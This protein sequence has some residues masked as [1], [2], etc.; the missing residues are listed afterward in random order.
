MNSFFIYTIE[1]GICLAAFQIAF[2]ILLRKDTFFAISR[3]YLLLTFI[4]SAILPA[5]N[6][7]NAVSNPDVIPTA[8]FSTITI[9]ASKA[10]QAVSSGINFG[11]I[12][13]VIYFTG[14]L[15]FLSRFIMRLLQLLNLTRK[16]GIRKID[17]YK[18]VF[19]ESQ[20]SPFSFFNIIFLGSSFTYNSETKNILAHEK[21]HIDKH[22]T[23]DILVAEIM[24]ILQWF[25]PFIWLIKMSLQEVHE[26]QA[27]EGVVKLGVDKSD[28]QKLILSKIAGSE[29]FQT[30]NNFSYQLIKRRIKMITK[31]KTKKIALV[32][33]MLIVPISLLLFLSFSCSQKEN[34]SPYEDVISIP[35]DKID[36]HAVYPTGWN[37]MWNFISSR[38][39][40][41][42]E[43]IEKNTCGK[44]AIRFE[45][46]IDGTIENV[47]VA[48][49]KEIGGEWKK[50]KLG[51]G[52]DEEA[53]RVIKE[54]PKWKP[55][56]SEGKPVKLTQSLILFFGSKEM[57]SKWNLLE[58]HQPTSVILNDKE[59][60]PNETIRVD[61]EPMVDLSLLAKAVKY[62]ETARLANKEGRVVLNV[63]VTKSGDVS[64]VKIL[65]SADAIFNESAMNA[66]KSVK[67][68]PA[69]N[70]GKNVYCWV[71]VPIN[72]RLK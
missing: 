66:V 35:K 22:H 46:D 54:M 64:E 70:E 11:E 15:I 45:V 21:V 69:V 59:Q 26:Y 14:V 47:R 29:I 39:K 62:P 65:E 5:L 63:L 8:L 58:K 34:L 1:S 67:F 20:Y 60:P 13:L 18:F 32:K 17:G 44:L 23:F 57:E 16:F 49:S 68:K 52:C 38:I 28:Y 19:T 53:T 10:E 9:E 31:A 3:V 36:S 27:D 71:C 56:I 2:L 55:A 61:E 25:N 43:L 41:P 37:D 51:Y 72:F 50:G 7:S 48:Q 6:F 42:K 33:L 4:V 12:M 30:A 24:T 40:T